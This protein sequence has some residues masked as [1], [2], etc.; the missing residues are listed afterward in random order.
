MIATEKERPLSL[1]SIVCG[2][3]QAVFFLWIYPR[4]ITGPSR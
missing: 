3:L 1:R 4:R 2:V